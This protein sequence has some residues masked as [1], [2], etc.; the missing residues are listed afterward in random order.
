MGRSRVCKYRVDMIFGRGTRMAPATFGANELPK[1]IERHVMAGVVA[2]MPGFI[3]EQIGAAF[4]ITIPARVTFTA[5]TGAK[6]GKVVREWTCPPFMVLPDANDYPE[7][8][9][10]YKANA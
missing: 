1:D 2:T 4:G 5:Q 8:A 10:A 6:A 7:V 3:N 9:K